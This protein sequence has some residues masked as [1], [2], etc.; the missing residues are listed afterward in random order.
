MIEQVYYTLFALN[1]MTALSVLLILTVH[2]FYKSRHHLPLLLFASTQTILFGYRFVCYYL[3]VPLLEQTC[4]EANI[5]FMTFSGAYLYYIAYFA[6]NDSRL[7]ILFA[8]GILT[9]VVS[10]V[11]YFIADRFGV[12]IESFSVGMNTFSDEAMI[13]YNAK[14]VFVLFTRMLHPLIMLCLIFRLKKSQHLK[15][16]SLM[17]FV[18]ILSIVVR[19]IYGK[20]YTNAV[21]ITYSLNLLFFLYLAYI[22]L[23]RPEAVRRSMSNKTKTEQALLQEQR[24]AQLWTELQ[25]YML[26]EKPW[27]NPQLSS[28]KIA[29]SLRTDKDT[30]LF[31]ISKY[32]KS[33][34]YNFIASYRIE[35]FCREI[36]QNKNQDVMELFHKVGFKSSS[37]AYIQ[38][39]RLKG[40]SPKV[41]AKQIGD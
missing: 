18:F 5:I 12:E 8:S 2:R 31:L 3:D 16:F 13:T 36:E 25:V 7:T 32:G 28:D 15:A 30:V 41:Y 24:L 38:F 21:C 34:I 22:H 14:V 39:K 10:L 29:D 11:L 1:F 37:S 20:V 33:N 26:K 6:F 35:E 9:F 40:V 27:L 4:I 17:T 23:L 19:N